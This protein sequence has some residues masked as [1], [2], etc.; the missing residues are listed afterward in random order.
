MWLCFKLYCMYIVRRHIVIL[1]RRVV[2]CGCV[3]NCVVCIMCSYIIIVYG[4]YTECGSVWNS[5]VCMYWVDMLLLCADG[6]LN[7]AVFESV[8]YLLMCIYIVILYRR[9]TK[10]GCVW[11]PLLCIYWVDILLF[12]HRPDIE[13]SCVWNCIVYI[14]CVDIFLLFADRILIVALFETVLY[15]CS[16]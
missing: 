11:N 4:R 16:E 12:M 9:G 3:W 2:E 8:L 14:S 10:C 7:V 5:I 6:V 1:Y 15:I 13:C